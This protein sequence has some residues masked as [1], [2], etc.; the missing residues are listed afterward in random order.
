MIARD[1]AAPTAPLQTAEMATLV[2]DRFSR[3]QRLALMGRLYQITVSDGTLSRH[4]EG[5][6]R[7]AATLLSLTP[8]DLAE[9]RQRVTPP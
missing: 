7:R 2:S 6:L 8:E 3:D 9:A 1:P 4:E 5:L